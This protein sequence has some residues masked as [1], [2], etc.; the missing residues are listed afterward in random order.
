MVCFNLYAVHVSIIV[1]YFFSFYLL[2]LNFEILGYQINWRSQ[3]AISWKG[4][5]SVA[6]GWY[7]LS[8]TSDGRTHRFTAADSLSLLQE[9]LKRATKSLLAKFDLDVSLN[10]SRLKIESFVKCTISWVSGQKTRKW[11]GNRELYFRKK[12]MFSHV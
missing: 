11:K 5:I 9:L 3:C 4:S 1:I 6:K 12:Q 2:S 7:S 10:S 8:A